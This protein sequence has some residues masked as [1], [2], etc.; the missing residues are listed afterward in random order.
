MGWEV[1]SDFSVIVP[2]ITA[3]IA[4]VSAVKASRAERNSRPTS[5]GFAA[6]VERSLK[7]LESHLEDLHKDVREVRTAVVD[8]LQNHP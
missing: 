6:G 8:H 5:N 3:L 7:A 1:M 2:I 4:G